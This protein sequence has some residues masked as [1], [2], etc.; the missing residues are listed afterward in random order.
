MKIRRLGA[1]LF[2]ADRRTD[3]MELTVAFRNSANAPT[4]VPPK[5]SKTAHSYSQFAPKIPGRR[6]AVSTGKELST[7]WWR[8]LRPS[9]RSSCPTTVGKYL[10]VDTAQY[11]RKLDWIPS[12]PLWATSC[13]QPAR[14]R[15]KQRGRSVS[16]FVSISALMMIR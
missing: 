5:F 11:P 8:V 9:L 13:S 14:I 7:L 1:E 15:R 6:H 3:M 10:S 16:N 12:I 2:L 4:K